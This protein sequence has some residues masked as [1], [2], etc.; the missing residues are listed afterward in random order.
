ML[1]ISEREIRKLINLDELIET[2]AE[3]MGELGARSAC[4]P[5]RVAASVPDQDGALTVMPG[6]IPTRRALTTKIVAQFPRNRNRPTHQAVLLTFDADHGELQAL[7]GA[8]ELTAARTAACSALA[9][10]LLARRDSRV[11]AIL[12]TGLQAA[13]HARALV[14]VRTITRIHVAGR[15]PGRTRTFATRLQHELQLPV[16]PAADYR[17]ALHAADIACATTHSVQP[18][19]RRSWLS[20]GTHICSVGHNPCGREIDDQTL[21]D[22]L[23]CV[24]SRHAALAA[25]PAGSNDLLDA[26][27]TGTITEDDIHAELPELVTGSKSGRSRREQITLYKSVGTAVQDAALAGPILVAARAAGVGQEVDLA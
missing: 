4:S 3:T 21:A 15:D 16:R 12:G 10:R 27:R 8:T 26:V 23:L 1:M 18:V 19:I 9:V 24:D 11:L 22:A 6:Y 25:F 14:R 7:L 2:V 20:P 17:D 5:H 13:W